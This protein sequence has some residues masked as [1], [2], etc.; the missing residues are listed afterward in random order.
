MILFWITAWL[1]RQYHVTTSPWPFPIIS[2]HVR[3]TKN[4]PVD[5]SLGIPGSWTLLDSS[6]CCIPDSVGK[7]YPASGLLYIFYMGRIICEIREILYVQKFTYVQLSESSTFASCV[8]D[9]WPPMNGNSTLT[10]MQIT[11]LQKITDSINKW[12]YFWSRLLCFGAVFWLA[13]RGIG[14]GGEGNCR[15]TASCC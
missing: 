5:S 2:P 14:L 12:G 6:V 15:L 10:E 13:T 7:N 8:N 1:S 3:E 4:S 11:S 9:S